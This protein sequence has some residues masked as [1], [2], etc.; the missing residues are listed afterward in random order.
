M[1]TKMSFL[2]F[3]GITIISSLIF[4]LSLTSYIIT[5][6]GSYYDDGF[7]L[8]FS[9]GDKGLLIVCI[10]S[11]LLAFLG[12]VLLIKWRKSK[13][14]SDNII[15]LFL[16]LLDL[17]FMIFVLSAILKKTMKGNVDFN[18]SFIIS[19]VSVIL[20]IVGVVAGTIYLVCVFQKKGSKRNL[21]ILSILLVASFS[22]AISIYCLAL[23]MSL[24]EAS[25]NVAIICYVLSLLNLLNFL[26]LSLN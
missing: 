13:S 7:G 9:Y 1:K 15:Q 19:I 17:I 5:A 8:S 16:T 14:I 11:F 10:I 23:G 6:I 12:T 26:P 21:V 18:A 2:K 20:S 25:K 24:F 3:A 22:L 4:I